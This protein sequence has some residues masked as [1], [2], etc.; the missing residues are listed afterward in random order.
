[1]ECDARPTRPRDVT[2][3]RDTRSHARG[4]C[5]I[6][7]TE[8]SVT[9]VVVTVRVILLASPPLADSRLTASGLARAIKRNKERALGAFFSSASFG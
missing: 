2:V 3:G 1:M 7:M 5:S 9:N 6:V 4:A 8:H